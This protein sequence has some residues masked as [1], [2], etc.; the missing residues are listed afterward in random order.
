MSRM[1]VAVVA[2]VALGAL[3]G[4]ASTPT[5]KPATA[6]EGARLLVGDGRVIENATLVV[7]GD[8][9]AQA[10]AASVQL[11]AGAARLILAGKTVMPMII[12]TH[13]HL[14]TE[15]NALIRDLKQRAYY[16]VSS[17]LSLGTDGYGLLDVRSE[18]IPG[19]ARFY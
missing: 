4:C 1:H 2:I 10:G 15:R 8:K 13:V 16:G 12:D 11:P 3:A 18:S 17:A 9:I 6:Y 7:E 19:V 5:G 14:N